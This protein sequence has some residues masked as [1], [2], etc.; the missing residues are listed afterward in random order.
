MG[1]AV[2]SLLEAFVLPS[3][4]LKSRAINSGGGQARNEVLAQVI[5]KL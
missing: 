2:A 4:R 1:V 5:C 3:V